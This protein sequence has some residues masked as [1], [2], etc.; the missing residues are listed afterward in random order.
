MQSQ[1]ILRKILGVA[2]SLGSVSALH[3]QS[4]PHLRREKSR[5]LG[6]VKIAK[7]NSTVEEEGWHGYSLLFVHS[8]VQRYRYRRLRDP[9]GY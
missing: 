4:K 1:E 7:D 2:V 8:Q 6:K 5:E 9:V 3:R